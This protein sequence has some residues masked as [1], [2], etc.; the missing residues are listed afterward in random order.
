MSNSAW[1]DLNSKGKI[2]KL[3]DKCPNPKCSCHKV[4]TFASHHYMLEGGSIKNK[5]Q[6]IFRR[7]QSAWNKV[8]QPAIN[9]TTPFKGMAVS[10]KTKNPKVEQATTNI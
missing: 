10:A 1:Y 9:A 4:I 8:P 6:K 5:I 3:H 7:T 2:L